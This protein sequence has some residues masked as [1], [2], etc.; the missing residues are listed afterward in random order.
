MQTYELKKK[1]MLA[2]W[3]WCQLLQYL[4]QLNEIDNIHYLNDKI[5]KEIETSDY[6]YI[7]IYIFILFYFFL[8]Y[9]F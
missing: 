6:G 2:D 8:Q 1:T 5:K 7:Y 4:M 9:M 3:Q